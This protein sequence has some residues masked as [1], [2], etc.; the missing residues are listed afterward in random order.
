MEYA[1]LLYKLLGIQLLAGKMLNEKREAENFPHQ[2]FAQKDPILSHG[3]HT[4]VTQSVML[5]LNWEVL[6]K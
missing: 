1:Y 5:Q 4:S 3:F 6:N 2:F